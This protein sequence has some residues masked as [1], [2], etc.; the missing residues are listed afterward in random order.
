LSSTVETINQDGK[1]LPGRWLNGD[2]TA[3]NTRVDP[4]QTGLYLRTFGVYG[5]SVFQR[6]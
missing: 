2:E 3:Q 4:E 6:R 5:Y 1:W